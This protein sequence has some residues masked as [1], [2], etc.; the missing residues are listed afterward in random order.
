MASEL[1]RELEEEIRRCTKCP[2][3]RHRTKAVPG[4][5]DPNAKVFFIGEAPGRNEDLEGRPFVGAAGKLL[6]RLLELA[7][8]SR[9]AVFITNVVKCRP[10]GNRDPRPEEIEACAPY[11]DRQLAAVRPDIVVTLGRHSTAYLLGRAGMQASS[12]MKTRGRIYRIEVE[13]LEVEVLP[14]LHPAAAL[15]NPRLLPLL[16]S[17]FSLLRSLLRGRAEGLERFF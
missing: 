16:E 9:S 1:L 10:P 3:H 15:Y 6:N 8:L 11:L 4:E 14:T 17:D 2:L 5:G 13:G 7:G 12:I